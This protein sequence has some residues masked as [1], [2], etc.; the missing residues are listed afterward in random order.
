MSKQPKV[1]VIIPTYNRADVLP[2]AINSI[3]NQSFDKFELIVV[4]D[5]STDNTQSV[6]ESYNDER[7]KYVVNDRKNGANAARNKGILK[8]RGEYI[9]F[10][11]SDDEYPSD[12]LSRTISCLDT[13]SS[14]FAGVCIPE[15]KYKG[16]NLLTVDEPPKEEIQLNDIKNGNVIGGFSTITV[17]ASIFD[18]IG[19]L[20]ESLPASQDYDFYIRTLKNK[21]IRYTDKTYVIRHLDNDRITTS[22]ERKQKGFERL[23]EKHADILPSSTISAQYCSLGVLYAREKNS[24]LA[25]REFRKAIKVDS[26]YI[27]P[28]ALYIISLF[29]GH[30]IYYSIISYDYLRSLYNRFKHMSI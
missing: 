3:I 9:S 22:P 16:D 15:Y 26:E 5:G 25:A 23:V 28:Y 27:L 4:D 18:K 6:V 8:S 30:P 1:S 21:K 11:D 2:R 14:E 29:G 17:C 19:L 20:D 13:L 10:L 12:N 7:V 24:P